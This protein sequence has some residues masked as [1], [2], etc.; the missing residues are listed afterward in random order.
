LLLI[1]GGLG[2]T[3]PDRVNI[4]VHR[5]HG[6]TPVFNEAGVP[7]GRLV[8]DKGDHEEYHEKDETVGRSHED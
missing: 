3:I 4:G 5:H 2:S 6:P 8:H 7:A 1:V